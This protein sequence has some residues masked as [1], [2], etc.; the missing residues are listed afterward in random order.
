MTDRV[1]LHVGG[2]KYEG[3]E[4]ASITRS[5]EAVAGSFNL[6]ATDRW[7][8][9]T[10]RWQIMPGDMCV[11]KINGTPIIT[12]YVDSISPSITG[13]SHEI[14]ITGR[15]KTADLV[16][17]SADV[18]SFEIRGQTL[19]SIAEMLC[20][21]FGIA[22]I[23]SG[24]T[25]EAFPSVAIQPGETV[26]SCIERLAK[27][28]KVAVTTNGNGDLV[29][30]QIGTGKADDALVEG[31]NI[32][33]ASATYDFAGRFSEYIV[34]GQLQSTGD[35][36]DAW[37]PPQNQVEARTKDANIKR[38][39][40]LILT[41]E[42]GV[43][44]SS[45]ATRAQLE[46]KKRAGDSSEINVTVQG[47][48]QSS[49]AIWPLNAM[50]LL[51]CPSLYIDESSFVIASVTFSIGSETTTAMVLKRADAYIEI[52]KPGEKTGGKKG[53]GD[54]TVSEDWWRD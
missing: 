16:D 36:E 19:K 2:K 39:R 13:D 23:A 14:S 26:W 48:T 17:C 44:E 6:T 3:W 31:A 45:A 20:K 49:G 47:W 52:E 43:Y 15:D 21:P 54:Q 27:Q 11:L 37:N 1:S 50:A 46:A 4:T 32:K 22:V 28:R 42:S 30:A 25:G 7:Y 10:E 33:A 12:G 40:P 41:A 38:Y 53:T 18:K 5:I 29:F 35:G 34:K 24:G 8:L 9:D 51:K